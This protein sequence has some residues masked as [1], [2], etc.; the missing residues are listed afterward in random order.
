MISDPREDHLF[1]RLILIHIDI[2]RS[3]Q[4]Q[5]YKCLKFI[6]WIR[7]VS[8]IISDWC[9]NYNHMRVYKLTD[10]ILYSACV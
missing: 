5:K 6:C 4:Y 10:T 9:E 3:Y 1:L 8:I 2:E 7:F